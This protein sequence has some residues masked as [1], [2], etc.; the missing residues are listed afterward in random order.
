MT[1]KI[2]L[3]MC[4]C[5]KDIRQKCCHATCKKF[6]PVY[7]ASE[8]ALNSKVARCQPQYSIDSHTLILLPSYSFFLLRGDALILICVVASHDF[9]TQSQFPST[10][11]TTLKGGASIISHLKIQSKN[12]FSW[13]SNQDLHR[14]VCIRAK[15]IYRQRTPK[16]INTCEVVYT[17][18]FESHYCPS[19]QPK[20]SIGCLL[21]C[22][23]CIRKS[24]LP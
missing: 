3:D 5:S 10:F 4:N 20:G 8:A 21:T 24:R 7:S 16:G 17:N 13:K 11:C 14:Q 6:R 15:A 22:W 18:T 23:L 12:F 2:L 1:S 9:H 19:V